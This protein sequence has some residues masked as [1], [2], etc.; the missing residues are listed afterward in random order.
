VST[1]SKRRELEDSG[2]QFLK[3]ENGWA[4]YDLDDRSEVPGS[5]HSRLGDCVWLAAKLLET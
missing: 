3:D 2:F 5:R 1:A 4:L